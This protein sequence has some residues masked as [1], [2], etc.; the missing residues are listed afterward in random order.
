VS[1]ARPHFICI[2]VTCTPPEPYCAY[3]FII[4]FGSTACSVELWKCSRD[5]NCNWSCIHWSRWN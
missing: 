4:I 5:S 2:P 3:Y 1:K